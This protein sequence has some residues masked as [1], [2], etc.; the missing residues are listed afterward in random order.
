GTRRPLP[1]EV[2][3]RPARRHHYL[4]DVRIG[5]AIVGVDVLPY[6]RKGTLGVR[7]GF[8]RDAEVVLLVQ[9]V[10]L[11]IGQDIDRP[12]RSTG[13]GA[14]PTIGDAAGREL[15]VGIVVVVQGEADLLEVI[16]AAHPAGRL[17]DLLHRR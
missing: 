3:P 4:V 8:I 12:V 16:G 6:D 14:A 2:G 1:A 11:D 7:V 15:A 9:I 5:R 10:L 17:A 13:G